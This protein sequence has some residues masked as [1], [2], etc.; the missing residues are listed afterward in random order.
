MRRLH[1][2]AIRAALVTLIGCAGVLAATPHP[3]HVTD[4]LPE[5]TLFGE[6]IVSTG[7]FESHPAFTPD[8]TTLQMDL[9]AL[10]GLAK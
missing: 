9:S 7:E 10:R 8:G 6:G 1:P 2:R 3:Y 4:P 5:P